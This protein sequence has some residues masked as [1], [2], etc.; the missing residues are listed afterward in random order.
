MTGVTVFAY[1]F[2]CGA[3]Y[4]ISS[5]LYDT[6]IR[7]ICPS[8]KH[9]SSCLYVSGLSFHKLFKSLSM[10][11]SCEVYDAFWGRL[12]LLF[13]SFGVHHFFSSSEH[14]C[15]IILSN[16]SNFPSGTREELTIFFQIHNLRHSGFFFSYF[17]D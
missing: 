8:R 15:N 10:L 4:S 13:G 1:A 12:L 2:F 16:L 7:H 3:A 6:P 14:E 11:R 17:F 5:N 9:V